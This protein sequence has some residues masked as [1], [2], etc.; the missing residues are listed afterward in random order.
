[1]ERTGVAAQTPEREGTVDIGAQFRLLRRIFQ[2]APVPGLIFDSYR[3]VGTNDAARMLISQQV[4][5][6]E[7]LV[8]ARTAAYATDGGSGRALFDGPTVKF[9]T[10]VAAPEGDSFHEDRLRICFLLPAGAAQP[11]ES[12]LDRFEL[13]APQRRV[14]ILLQTGKK[15][16]EIAEC[17]GLATETVRKHVAHILMKTGTSTRAAFVA[18][19]L[20]KFWPAFFGSA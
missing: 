20:P 4:L 1:M 16:R 12:T 14:A 6:P 5:T 17:L 3:L 7:L 8:K 18:L 11:Y 2:I 15:N 19:A 10:L 13:S 9:R